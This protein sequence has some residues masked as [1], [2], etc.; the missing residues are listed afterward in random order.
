MPCYD[1][2][3][4]DVW[5]H[6][7]SRCFSLLFPHYSHFYGQWN[8]SRFFSTVYFSVCYAMK[9]KLK[10]YVRLPITPELYLLYYASVV[11][12]P[13]GHIVS[14][15]EKIDCIIYSRYYFAIFFFYWDLNS[16]DWFL[17]IL[18]VLF[19]MFAMEYSNIFSKRLFQLTLVDNDPQHLCRLS[20]VN[21]GSLYD[22]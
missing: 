6:F 13:Q 15:R 2:Y 9:W 8:S 11:G 19:W 3:K 4:L 14:V 5:K 22:V 12:S 10:F 16:L 1:Y 20:R 17:L 21:C 18:M 7:F